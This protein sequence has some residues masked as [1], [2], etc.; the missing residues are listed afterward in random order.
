MT[1][2]NFKKTK[3]I[4]FGTPKF[5]ADILNKL[6]DHFSI[7]AVIT[8]PDTKK[9]NGKIIKTPVKRLAQN[10]NLVIFQ[11]LKLKNN[12]KLKNK[13]L[14][15]DPDFFVVASY[16]LIIPK[17]ILEIP[18]FAPLNIHPSL[19]PKYRGACPIRAAIKNDDELT[20]VTI[21][22]MDQKLD[23]GPIYK[24]ERLKIKS[25]YDYKKLKMELLNL[26]KELIVKTI[27]DILKKNIKLTPQNHKKASYTH[28]LCKK[29]GKI[30]WDQDAQKIKKLIQA[31]CI[32][33][34][35]YTKIHLPK[36][37]LHN[38]I[39][40]IFKTNIFKK[41][42]PTGKIFLTN[43]NWPGVYCKE[44]ALILEKIQLPGKNIVSGKDLYNGHNIIKKAKLK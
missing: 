30:N 44:N 22:K 9:R 12:E 20:G 7:Q 16:G 23:H 29:D 39:L 32:K 31:Y 34:G 42:G 13:L 2:N 18:N 6:N 36:T 40:K 17:K 41:S 33:P 26:S 28:K 21:I 25:D 43:N 11:P 38:N 14:K 5:G 27:K 24:Q 19:L 1:K 4:F 35:S 3:I 8:T 15:L 10:K 37:K